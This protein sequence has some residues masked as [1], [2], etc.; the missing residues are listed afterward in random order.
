MRKVFEHPASHEVGLCESILKSHGIEVEV[1]NLNSSTLSGEV[2]FASAYAELWV[3]N[4]EDYEEAIRLL[5][6]YRS[7]PAGGSSAD[8]EC[9]NCRETVPGSFALCWNCQAPRGADESSLMPDSPRD[10]RALPEKPVAAAVGVFERP[11]TLACMVLAGA[12]FA[13][14][15]A[16]Y[17]L[18]MQWF[19]PGFAEIYGGRWDGMLGCNFVHADIF[20]LAFNLYWLWTFGSLL[21]GSIRRIFWVLIFVTC[22]VFASAAQLAVDGETGIGLSGVVYGLF[23]FLWTAKPRFPSFA[24]VLNRNTILLLMGWLILCF[25]L[26]RL[27]A[28]AVANWAHVGGLAAGVLLG[29]LAVKSWKLSVCASVGLLAVSMASLVYAPWSPAF[30]V[31]RAAE[32]LQQGKVEQAQEVLKK[33]ENT[34]GN[35]GVGVAFMSGYILQQQGDLAGAAKVFE[36][37]LGKAESNPLFLNAYAWLLAT[38]PED[39]VRDGAKA[40]KLALR[41][42]ELT[43][44]KEAAYVDT[45]AAAYA[46][47]G[48]FES[49]VKWQSEA[50]N[51]GLKDK[52]VLDRLELY[53]QRKPFRDEELKAKGT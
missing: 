13:L 1:R 52:G 43:G 30:L 46:E 41:A 7:T 12:V 50:V 11:F 34:E 51:L 15:T 29:W 27:G 23:G 14:K 17:P 16:N 38:S 6:E 40:V 42:S 39:G 19:A 25:W 22:G 26:T 4:D 24:T 53:K 9:R 36:K 47:T 21:E 37:A 10:V 35:L 18:A 45:L 49:A 28:Y 44:W 5:R 32:Y 20:H 31:T 48:D 33:I 8:W 2:P 3:V